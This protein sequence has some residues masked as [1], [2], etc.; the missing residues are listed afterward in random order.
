MRAARMVAIGNMVCEQA[1][2]DPPQEGQ[3][4]VR[5]RE[6]AICGSDL[7]IVYDGLKVPAEHVKPGF[8]G[9]EGVGE[10]VESRAPGFKAGDWVLTCPYSPF[11]R[12]FAEYLTLPAASCLK[13]PAY[14][15]PVEHLLMAQ[16]FGT[17]MFALRR[18]E[19]DF[20]GKTVMVMG[21][22]SAGVFFAWMAKRFGAKKV[23]VSDLSEAR[24][25]Q[26]KFTGA[27]VAVRADAQ[28]D[29]VKATVDEHTGGKG[30]DLVI[31][32]VGKRTSLL[33]SVNLVRDGG[34]MVF[35]G[36]PDTHEPV[37]F[38]FH[39]FF[40]KRV[41]AYSHWGT[42]MEPGLVSFQTA[43]DLI[44]TGQIDVSELVTHRLPLE[45]IGQ[46]LRI[47]QE[48]TDGARKVAITL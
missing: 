21:Q 46:A 22:G 48:R 10:V 13:L 8:P 20:V 24:L 26:S 41:G 28:G 7:H 44:A 40:R 37:P 38:N 18:A 34:Q 6:A 3:L 17:T 23:I 2:I 1:E 36:L 42:Q 43:L 16:Q 32:A 5:L 14:K 31:E 35:F 11:G 33:Q 27:D 4:L 9:H 19:F 15:G 29:N 47:A 39:D 12:C 30:A 25:T 45:Q